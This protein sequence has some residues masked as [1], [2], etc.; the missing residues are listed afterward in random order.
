MVQSRHYDISIQLYSKGE[1]PVEIV[2]YDPLRPLKF[3]A[4]RV[5]LQAVLAPWLTGPIEH[6]DQCRACLRKRRR[7]SGISK[8]TCR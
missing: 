1:A 2:Q 6:V 4:E 5:L 7:F 8:S 3:E